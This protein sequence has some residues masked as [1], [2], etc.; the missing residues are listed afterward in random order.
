MNNRRIKR[1]RS[2]QYHNPGVRHSE[3]NRS[4]WCWA[5]AWRL[6]RGGGRRGGGGGNRQETRSVG[7]KGDQETLKGFEINLGRVM[8]R[9][10]IAEC[11]GPGERGQMN[12]GG[13]HDITKFL[14][15]CRFPS[16]RGA[17][18]PNHHHRIRSHS[19][20]R[21]HT[22]DDCDKS[23]IEGQFLI[24]WSQGWSGTIPTILA[25]R[26][27]YNVLCRI[28]HRFLPFLITE[29]PQQQRSAANG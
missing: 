16:T 25:R 22:G 28:E 20:Q 5:G 19:P 18:N 10:R 13:S 8:D 27:N 24:N 1:K 4:C 21:F 14:R 9:V 3:R 7:S 17:T 26:I 15:H 29:Q 6:L 23:L 11:L 2:F 12:T